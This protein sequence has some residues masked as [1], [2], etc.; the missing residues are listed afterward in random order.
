MKRKIELTILIMLVIIGLNLRGVQANYQSSPNVSATSNYLG[1]WTNKNTG[2]KGMSTA[3]GAIGATNEI[4]VH[5]QKNT[6]Y[7]AMLIFAVSDYGK[8][9]NG[10]SGSDWISSSDYGL[11]TTTGNVSGIYQIGSNYEFVAAGYEDEKYS[12]YLY[13]IDNRER[14]LYT[15]DTKKY[16]AGDAMNVCAWQGA[17]SSTWIN[18]S[19]SNQRR[20]YYYAF[21]RKGFLYAAAETYD[22]G[23]NTDALR[24]RGNSNYARACIING[25]S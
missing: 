20:F 13:N 5:L 15:V 18:I 12:Y 6:E 19:G 16:I 1:T 8:Q 11:A 3:S 9:G 14:D 10:T 23:M 25:V 17:S 22:S 7:G 24:R 2:I 21:T 4:N